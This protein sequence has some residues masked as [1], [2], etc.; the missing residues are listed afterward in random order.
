MSNSLAAVINDRGLEGINRYYSWYI[1]IVVD[2]QDSTKRNRLRVSVPDVDTSYA[3]WALSM[4][5]PGGLGQGFKYQ[6]PRVGD[7]VWITFEKGD[8]LYPVWAP[9][10]W[11]N[12]EKPSDLGNDDI[13]MV[14]FG[15]NK[16][17]LRDNENKLIIQI[18]DA[19]DGAIAT[20][21]EINKGEINISCNGNANIT[22]GANINLNGDSQGIPL[23]D[24]VVAKLNQLENRINSLSQAFISAA[25]AAIPM[26][27]GTAA[28]TSLASWNTPP[29]NLTQQSEIENPK[30]KEQ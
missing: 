23:T 12:K 13:G 10:G 16:I 20:T 18:L 25:A 9:F 28:F 17:I 29:I 3:A 30:V 2:D 8:P 14:T 15:G 1:G 11:F 21:L 6:T 4:G 5:Q 22:T 27:G 26:D 24:Q 7:K 19:R